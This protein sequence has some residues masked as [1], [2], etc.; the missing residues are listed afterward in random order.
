VV[1]ALSDP[2]ASAAGGGEQLRSRGLDVEEGLLAEEALPVLEPWLI[3]VSRKRPYVTW[4]YAATLDGRVAAADGTSQWI[5][6][7]DARRDVHRERHLADAVIAGIGTIVADDA[8]LT[9][10]DWPATRQPRRVVVDTD[11]RTPVTARVLDGRASTLIAV[12]EDAP[13]SRTAALRTSG[14]DV[15]A[16]PRADVGLD[17]VALLAVLH[18]REIYIALL[19]GGATLAASFLRG[20]LVDRVVGYH[21]P[22]LF[23]AGLPLVADLGIST[24][25]SATRLHLADVTT[26][27]EDLRIIAR[28]PVGGR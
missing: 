21:A 26:L 16:V 9:V 7:S 13:P 27:G 4:K 20:G 3:G 23:G 25:D 28:V 1:Y 6:G 11:A 5:T 14:A 8:R 12:A 19:E 2:H 24:L 17:L 15:I 22:M 10:R 18:D